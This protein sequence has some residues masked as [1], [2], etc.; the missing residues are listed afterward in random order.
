MR[1]GIDVELATGQYDEWERG[2]TDDEFVTGGVWWG[3]AGKRL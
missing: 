2:D 1:G 3:D